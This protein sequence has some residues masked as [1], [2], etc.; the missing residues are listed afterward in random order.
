MFYEYTRKHPDFYRFRFCAIAL[1]KPGDKRVHVSHVAIHPNNE[2][3]G[4]DGARMHVFR[5]KNKYEPGFYR[6]FRNMN[7]S[8][9]FAKAKDYDESLYPEY[10]SLFDVK[11]REPDFERDFSY[12]QLDASYCDVI[13]AMNGTGIFRYDFFKGLDGY[14]K[15]FIPIPD[16]KT[17]QTKD[18]LV[19]KSGTMEV[20]IMPM[21]MQ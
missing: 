4:S 7:T 14:F 3:T 15:V 2:V 20:A 18:P 10:K 1:A 12:R 9:I 8:I 21:R 19:L 17:N 13:L 11:G 16:V 6:V 5:P